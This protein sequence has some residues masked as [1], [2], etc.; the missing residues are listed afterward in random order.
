MAFSIQT[1]LGSD[2]L[3]AEIDAKITAAFTFFWTGSFFF[4]FLKRA[5]SAQME[6]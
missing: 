6:T 5:V 3:T 4:F 2:Y 1:V